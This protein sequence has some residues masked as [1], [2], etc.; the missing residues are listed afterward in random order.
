MPTCGNLRALAS[1]HV[2][3][4]LPFIVVVPM[5]VGTVM[6]VTQAGDPAGG[7]GKIIERHPIGAARR[8]EPAP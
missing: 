6:R 7:L 5:Q 1:V 2:F 3:V 4:F 8:Y